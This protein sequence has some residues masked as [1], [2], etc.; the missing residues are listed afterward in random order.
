[1]HVE[2]PALGWAFTVIHCSPCLSS[3]RRPG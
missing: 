2:R 3:D 1:M